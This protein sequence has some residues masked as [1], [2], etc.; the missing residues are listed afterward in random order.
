MGGFLWSC[1]N[2]PD[3][4]KN[5]KLTQQ[6]IAE[7]AIKTW[8]LDS[9]DYPHYKP[10]VFGDITPRFEKTSST[11]Q[12]SIEI[13]EEE[14]KPLD[15]QNQPMLDSLKHEL[16][17][18]KTDLLGYLVAH[19][20]QLR[21]MAGDPIQK[22]LLFFLDTTLTIASAVSPEAFDFILDEKVFFKLDD[23]NTD[24]TLL[25]DQPIF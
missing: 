14:S 15:E 9:P 16:N 8:M 4:G 24:S 1:N 7:D 21:N 11:L 13:S 5:A 23:S 18:H 19:K 25:I 6:Q 2:N 10:I 12:L 20:F 3:A 17:K 22:E